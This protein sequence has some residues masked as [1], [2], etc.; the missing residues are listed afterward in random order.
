MFTAQLE[1]IFNT[2]LASIICRNSDHV[3]YA[4]RYVMKKVTKTNNMEKCSDIDRFN[5]A[6][7]REEKRSMTKVDVDNSESQ[8][9]TIKN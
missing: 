9:R 8:V 3:E 7:W 1:E 2:T 6:P 4:Q 5:F